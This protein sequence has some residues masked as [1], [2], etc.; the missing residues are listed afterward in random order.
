MIPRDHDDAGGEQRARPLLGTLVAIRIAGAAADI[1]A[2]FEAAFAR[3][4]AVHRAMSFHDADSELSRLN[5]DAA[6][7]PR[8][9]GPHLWRVLRASLALARASE[10]RFDPT[11]AARLVQSQHLPAPANAPAPDPHAD[12]RDVRLLPGRRVRFDRPLWLDFGGIAK[13]YAV[14]LAVAA[15]RA[16]DVRSGMVN[17]GG[18]LRVFGDAHETIRVRDPR[19]PVAT[20]P[21]LQ[22]RDG[23]VATSSG[24][25]SALDGRTALLDGR[26][27]ARLGD[28]VSVSVCAPRALWA[29][30]LT[31]IVLADA[32]AALPLLHR[33]RAQAALLDATGRVRTL[34]A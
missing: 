21:L 17:A 13:G 19:D 10:G 16:Q 34:P 12:W 24:Y 25:F 33:L 7:A 22:L 1:D 26:S 27:G 4:V 8:P 20:R 14:D 5:R 31:K 29:D 9:V 30:A 28:D 23:A 32:D 15:L 18:D 6:R 2:A 3:I 11:I